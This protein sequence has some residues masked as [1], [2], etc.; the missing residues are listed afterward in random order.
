MKKNTETKTKILLSIPEDLKDEL[1][2]EAQ[3]EH[4]SMNNY[5]LTVLLK[6]D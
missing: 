2:K 6:R 4:R 3:E 1:S 5:I